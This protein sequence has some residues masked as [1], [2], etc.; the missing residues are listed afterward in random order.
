MANQYTKLIIDNQEIDLFKAEALPLNIK[1]RVNSLS[2]EVQGDYSRASVTVPATKNNILILGKTRAFFS[3]RIEVDGSPSFSGTAQTKKIKTYSQGYAALEENYEINLLSSNASWFVLL[4]ETKLS[5]LTSLVITFDQPTIITGLVAS[6]LVIDYAFAPIKWKEWDNHTGGGPNIKYQPSYFEMTPCLYYKPF[7]IAAFN[8]IGYTV[9]SDFLDTDYGS[10][11]VI[12]VPIPEKLSA[13]YND[14][15]LNTQVSM[16]AP[17]LLVSLLPTQ[18]LVYDTIDIAAPSNPTAYA[19][20]TGLYTCPLDGYYEVE[21]EFTFAQPPPPPLTVTVFI[22]QIQRNGLFLSP[23]VGVAFSGSATQPYP[24][25]PIR[26]STILQ[27]SAGETINAVYGYNGAVNITMNTATMKITGEAVFQHGMEL[28]FQYMLG[29]SLFNDS[30]KGF[31]CLHNLGFET[32]ESAR[33]VTIEPKDGYLNTDR[34]AVLSERKEGF[35][36]DT[37]TKDYTHLIDYD[38]KGEL[39]IQ[40]VAGIFVYK[41]KSDADRTE[42]FI[43]GDDEIAIYE[44]QFPMSN[45]ADTSK[46]ETKEV[47]FFAKTIH[48]L[49]LLARYPDTNVTPQFPLI[50]PQNYILNPTATVADTEKTIRL[51]YFAGQRTGYEEKDGQMEFF[52]DPGVP[53]LV[54]M[55]FM[56]NYNDDTGLDPNMGFDNQIIN[57]TKSTG[58]LQRFYLQNLARDNEGCLRKNYVKFNSIDDLNFSFRVKGIIDSQ[59]YVVQELEGFNPLID[60]P[61]QFKFYLDVFPDADDVANIIDSP[62]QGLALLLIS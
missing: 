16:A 4:G 9:Q 47:P 38:K 17:T 30:L 53:H 51:L 41:W 8:S 27:L 23:N 60:A 55:C 37:T 46:V 2:G 31:T 45:G 29:N 33:I 62:V 61:T 13:A 58:L 56:V 20:G 28:D 12:D 59:R 18:V 52:E 10:K 50:Y 22:A 35:Y 14:E 36:K 43:Q 25:Q 44:A 7:I 24:T 6:P 26:V 15:Y 1:K 21:I 5:D 42:E 19:V 32:D 57:G 54:P 3:F 49:D 40:N 34:V 48:T 11:L 39:K